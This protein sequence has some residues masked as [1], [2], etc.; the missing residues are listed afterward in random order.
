MPRGLAPAPTTPCPLLCQGGESFSGQEGDARPASKDG[1]NG[2]NAKKM[3]NL[4]SE[5]RKS[6]KIKE[7]FKKRT[8]NELAF[9]SKIGPSELNRWPRKRLLCSHNPS[10]LPPP[11]RGGE[12]GLMEGATR[13]RPARTDEGVNTRKRCFLTERTQGFSANKGLRSRPR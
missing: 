1:R 2:E 8:Q 12:T 5:P 7:S 4:T 9:A 6:L 11:R 3:L 13:N 10:P